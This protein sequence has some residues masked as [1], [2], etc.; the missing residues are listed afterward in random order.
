M[1]INMVD[2]CYQCYFFNYIPIYIYMTTFFDKKNGKDKDTYFYRRGLNTYFYKRGLHEYLKI[3]KEKIKNSN[4][5]ND[6]QYEMKLLSV[7]NYLIDNEFINNDFK[8]TNKGINELQ[9]LGFPNIPDINV[10]ITIKQMEIFANYM[11]DDNVMDSLIDHFAQPEP[12][13]EPEP[14][15]QPKPEP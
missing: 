4:N 15:P 14:E 12:E 5:N 6:P 8:W 3:L 7:P 13:P 11:T 9:K 2:V 10:E 1:I